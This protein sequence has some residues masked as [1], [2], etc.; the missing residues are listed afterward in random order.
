MSVKRG[1][2]DNK[3]FSDISVGSPLSQLLVNQRPELKVEW[4]RRGTPPRGM[5]HALRQL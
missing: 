5:G 1:P 4:E 2:N 3:R